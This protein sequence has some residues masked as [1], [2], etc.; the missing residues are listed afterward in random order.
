MTK[1]QVAQMD[2]S[3]AE[4]FYELYQSLQSLY[5]NTYNGPRGCMPYKEYLGIRNSARNCYERIC[6]ITDSL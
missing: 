1:E 3:T 4:A 2:Y 5:E 6:Q